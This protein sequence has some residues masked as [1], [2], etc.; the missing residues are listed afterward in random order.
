MNHVTRILAA[1]LLSFILAGMFSSDQ[2]PRSEGNDTENPPLVVAFC[3]L[4]KNP[5]RYHKALVRTQAILLEGPEHSMLYDPGC[6]D[7]KNLTW[8]EWDGYARALKAASKNVQ[9]R[10][11]KYIKSDQRA[12]VT[13]VGTFQGKPDVESPKNV[14][15]E[16]AAVIKR[17]NEKA[18]FGHLGCCPHQLVPAAIEKVDRVPKS[19]PLP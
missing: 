8:F 14:S 17:N 15:P 16:V 7:P 18:G 5:D 6:I 13:V 10:L 3:D 1:S 19:V 2:N 9:K 4:V 12:R 11:N